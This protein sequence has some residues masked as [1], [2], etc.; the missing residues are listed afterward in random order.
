MVKF[1]A[2]SIVVLALTLGGAA[3]HTTTLLLDG[4]DGDAQT[5]SDRPK[6]GMTMANVEKAYGM[7]AE[8][9][10]AVGQPPITRWDYATFSVYFENDRVIHAVARR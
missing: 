3:G 6:S 5:A 2:K 1:V 10:E 9:H 8:R 4:I 7:P